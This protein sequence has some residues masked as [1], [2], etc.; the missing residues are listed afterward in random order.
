VQRL[1]LVLV[2]GNDDLPVL[3]PLFRHGVPI[4][5]RGK[6]RSQLWG[7]NNG[8]QAFRGSRGCSSQG[9]DAN[10]ASEARLEIALR[11]RRDHPKRRG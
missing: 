3:V 6:N 11:L 10:G 5:T 4:R 7:R 8:T 2:F 9:W 1:V